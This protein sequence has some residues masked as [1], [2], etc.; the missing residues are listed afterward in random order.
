[1]RPSSYQGFL[2]LCLPLSPV[3]SLFLPFSLFLCLSL[4]LVSIS[5]LHSNLDGIII[6]QVVGFGLVRLE[7]LALSEE[8]RSGE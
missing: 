3:L 5:V 8:A 1:M 7:D 4:Y 2:F 6:Q